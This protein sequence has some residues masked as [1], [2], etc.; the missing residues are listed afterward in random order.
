MKRI[1]V[2]DT[3]LSFGRIQD[4]RVRLCGGETF[5]GEDTFWMTWDEF[6]DIRHSGRVLIEGIDKVI[7]P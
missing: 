2:I 1:E 4:V 7:N 6:T 5:E 3:I